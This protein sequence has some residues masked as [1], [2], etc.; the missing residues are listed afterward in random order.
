MNKDLQVLCQDWLEACRTE[1]YDYF[2][3]KHGEP[4]EVIDT[5][6]GLLSNGGKET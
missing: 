3:E 5:F 4:E 2:F 6:V 1:D